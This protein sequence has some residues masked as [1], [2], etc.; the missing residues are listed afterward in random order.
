M[1]AIQNKITADVFIVVI[2]IKLVI[3]ELKQIS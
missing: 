1:D 3:T 2:S